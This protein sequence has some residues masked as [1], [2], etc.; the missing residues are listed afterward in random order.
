MVERIQI[1]PHNQHCPDFTAAAFQGLRDLIVGA[2]PNADPIEQLENAWKIQND[3]EKVLWDAQVAAD[4]LQQPPP[5]P[6]QPVPATIPGDGAPPKITF[7]K[8][9]AV[10]RIPSQMCAYVPLFYATRAGLEATKTSSTT[11]SNEGYGL[12]TTSQGLQFQPC[13]EFKAYAHV[14]PDEELSWADVS[15]AS[16]MLLSEIKTAG[17][18]EDVILALHAF[19]YNIDGLD[20]RWL[21]DGPEIMVQYQ[22]IVRKKWHDEID[23]KTPDLFDISRISD[24][25]LNDCKEIVASRR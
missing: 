4:A 13:N 7:T 5:V 18:E 16:R 1:N 2:N 11:V 17:W 20:L 14:I 12:V 19:F 6:P 15:E 3:S 21:E 8:G 10:S 25:V 24:E 22:V 9:K 23:K